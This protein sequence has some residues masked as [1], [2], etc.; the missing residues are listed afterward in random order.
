MKVRNAL[1]GSALRRAGLRRIRR[2]L[3][4]ASA[5]LPLGEAETALDALASH[6]SAGDEIVSEAIAWAR[7]ASGAA[8]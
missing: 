7:R 8:V 3:A 2:T 5:R 1:V 6:P 4:Y